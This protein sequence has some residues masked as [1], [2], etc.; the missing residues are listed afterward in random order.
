M[1]SITKFPKKNLGDI[2]DSFS[3][4]YHDRVISNAQTTIKN[5][6][7][8]LHIN[9]YLTNRSDVQLLFAQAVH[10]VLMENVMVDA[11]IELFRIG[12]VHLPP[13]VISKSLESAIAIQKNEILANTQEVVV[14]R[15]E[16]SK[17]VAEV[18]AQKNQVLNFAINTA[19][20][21]V[22]NSRSYARQV[23]IRARGLGI[24]SMLE[25]LN[26]TTSNHTM[27]IVNRL[28]QIDNSVNTKYVTTSPI[29]LEIPV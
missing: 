17:L 15:A 1:I 24:S 27:A 4:N 7:A 18:D 26:F 8:P 10:D 23:D 3:N 21:M 22:E 29:H 19:K 5:I 14:I 9:D 12:E 25:L 13:S 16:T 2:Y 20:L 11:P 28:A 6:A